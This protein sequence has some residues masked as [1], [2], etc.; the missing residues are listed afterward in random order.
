MRSGNGYSY[1]Y[2]ILSL[3]SQNNMVLPTGRVFYTDHRNGSVSLTIDSLDTTLV[4]AYTCNAMNERGQ[5]MDAITVFGPPPPPV[6]PVIMIIS[7]GVLI[8]WKRPSTDVVITSYA[9]AV[10]M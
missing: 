10:Y 1:T 2:L 6:D 9:I 7:E 4:G 5:D 3:P 8:T